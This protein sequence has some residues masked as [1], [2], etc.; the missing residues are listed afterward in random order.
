MTEKRRPTRKPRLLD[1]TWVTVAV[2]R[3]QHTKL[4]L[5]ASADHTSIAHHVRRAI[6]R[7]LQEILPIEDGR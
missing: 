4:N 1:V 7:Y 3:S 2:P 5:L 6:E